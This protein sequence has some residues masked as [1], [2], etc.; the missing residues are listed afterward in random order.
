MDVQKEKWSS[1][2]DQAC[3]V[4]LYLLFF[5]IPFS[6]ALVASFC[7]F[8]LL[9]FI[10]R[11]AVTKG[12]GARFLK[13]EPL[14][15][16]LFIA[17]ALSLINSGPFIFISLRA[18]FLKWAKYMVLY[19]I[20]SQSLMTAPRIKYALISFSAG[21]VLV[22]LDCFSQ[23]FLNCEFLGQR[24]MVLH[25]TQVLAVTGPFN[26]NNGL[27][28]YLACMLIVI[29]YWVFS[30]ATQVMKSIAAVIFLSGIF[31][32]VHAYSRGGWIAFIVSIIVL[33]CFLRRF[34]FLGFSLAVTLIL[35][36]KINWLKF[37]AFKDSGRFELWAI[38]MRMIKD[39]PLL[40]NGIGAYMAWF[41][42]F[43]STRAISY[44]H[45]CYLQ[46]WAEAGLVA[47]IVFLVFISKVC[48]EGVLLYRTTKDLVLAVLVCAILAYVCHSF[49]DTD[50]FSTSLGFLFWGLMGLL[51]A[52]MYS[53]RGEYSPEVT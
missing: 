2:F 35:G 21:A 8:V 1:F 48:L 28:V 34:W 20:I 12:L 44:A 53:R 45:N 29:L 47:L 6:S 46:L 27:S 36:F 33:A 18:L 16:F 49:F 10:G 41:R 32:L 9:F 25:A 39:H 22:I 30:K 31:I 26:H 38:T 4:S 23:L 24:H 51:K 42:S 7:G 3:A 52:S 14:L 17:L 40:G 19:L 15:A 13:S 50:L 5:C 11:L 43:S 37:L